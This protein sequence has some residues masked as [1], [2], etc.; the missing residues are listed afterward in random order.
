MRQID[1]SSA[2]VT[3]LR[4]ALVDVD[5]AASPGETGRTVT[6]H[7]MSH[8][9]AE[10]AV[11]AYVVGALNGLAF[12]ATYGAGSVRVHVRGTLDAGGRAVLRLEEVL[13]T[14]GAGGESRVRVHSRGTL[15]ATTIATRRSWLIRKR[16]SWTGLTV[17]VTAYRRLAGVAVSGTLQARHQTGRRV[18]AVTAD[19]YTIVYALG[20]FLLRVRA[21][22]TA[23]T[24]A[25]TVAVL[26]E[27]LRAGCALLL[28]LTGERSGRTVH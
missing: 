26:I 9:H 28:L 17:L 7:A 6:V 21:E 14:L 2:V 24:R 3:R 10:T 20:T 27:A 15:G 16:A 19:R 12:L 25:L 1:A 5:L 8:R 18:C 22:R 11:L 23:Q 13:G 4:R